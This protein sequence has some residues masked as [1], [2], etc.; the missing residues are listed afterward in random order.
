MTLP[1]HLRA[2]QVAER[3]ARVW[4]ERRGLEHLL[5]NYCCRAGELDLVMRDGD[6]TVIVEVRYR[7]HAGFGGA[8]ASVSV[9]K[10]QRICRATEQLLRQ[11]RTLR[12]R[13][14]R[15]DVVALT[16]MPPDTEVDWRRRAFA[17]ETP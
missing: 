15:F 12:A 16:G 11:H 13:P 2:G 6:C 8:L 10:Q 14:L 7:A 17:A 4:L 5:S 3:Y 1:P 9:P